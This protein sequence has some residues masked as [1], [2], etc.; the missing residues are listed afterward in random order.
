MFS[1]AMQIMGVLVQMLQRRN[2]QTV[3]RQSNCNLYLILIMYCRGQQEQALEWKDVQIL[4]TP[5]LTKEIKG[6]VF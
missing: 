6:E 2:M 4:R 5:S 1:L 3:Y